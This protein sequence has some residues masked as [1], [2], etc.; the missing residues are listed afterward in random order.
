[1]L[2]QS[3]DYALRA[4]LYVAQRTDDGSCS[5]DVVA[6]ATGIPRNYLGKVLHAL[7]QAH[8]LTS[9]RG[10]NG[11]FRL[12]QPAEL[13]SLADVVEPFQK[14]PS[15]QVCL[16]GNRECDSADPCES[17]RRWQDMADRITSFFRDTTVAT[18]LRDQ[19]D[20]AADGSNGS[21]QHAVPL[22]VHGGPAA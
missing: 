13:L 18:M 17:H 12:A 6:A 7:T 19:V 10:P 20:P 22:R 3:A 21:R 2:N 8:V 15:R 11:G 1:M 14:L 5:A 16:R 4:V 9:I